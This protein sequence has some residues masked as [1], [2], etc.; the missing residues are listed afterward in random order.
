MKDVEGLNGLLY[1]I[2]V[3]W[4]HTY[5][6]WD[7]IENINEASSENREA[8]KMGQD[9]KRRAVLDRQQASSTCCLYNDH[10]P[11][12]HTPERLMEV[13]SVFI[14][15]NKDGVST[16]SIYGTIEVRDSLDRFK[17][18]EKEESC[19]ENLGDNRTLTLQGPLTHCFADLLGME[20]DLKDNKGNELCK[21]YLNWNNGNLT[22]LWYERRICSVIPGKGGYAALHYT[23]FNNDVQARVK[24]F[25]SS[26]SSIGH[27]NVSGRIV[28]A[29]NDLN[30]FTSYERDYYQSVLFSRPQDSPCQLFQCH[31][32][33]LLDMVPDEKGIIPIPLS[34]SVVC[35]PIHSSLI[36][37]VNLSVGSPS[38][39]AF[40]GHC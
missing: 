24:V 8:S 18:F 4:S 17:I 39:E 35:V 29:Y 38:V 30:Y 16:T 19:L 15:I 10:I 33:P 37:D 12:L 1:Q 6:E 31:E 7:E 5:L 34:K 32:L 40:I 9:K 14:G 11:V 28:T 3:K 21:G 20:V 27:T 23:I 22:D 36:I 25:F 26:S 2:R 13:F